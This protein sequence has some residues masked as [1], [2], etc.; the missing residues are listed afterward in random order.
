MCKFL[1]TILLCPNDKYYVRLQNH[2]CVKDLF[3][4]QNSLVHFK[5]RDYEKLTALVTK[6]ILQVNLQQ[7]ITCQDLV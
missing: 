5:V 3:T 1:N 2:A 7:T 6:Y 4:I